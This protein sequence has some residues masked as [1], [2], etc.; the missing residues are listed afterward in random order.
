[1]HVVR[2]TLH[3]AHSRIGAVRIDRKD[4]PPR[5]AVFKYRRVK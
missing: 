1:M 2:S 4:G 3:V 5:E